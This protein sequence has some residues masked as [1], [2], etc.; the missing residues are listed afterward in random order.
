[1]YLKKMYGSEI[2][3]YNL[4]EIDKNIEMLKSNDINILKEKVFCTD[5]ILLEYSH[6]EKYWQLKLN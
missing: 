2:I 5:S 3:P 4:D 1:M 6:M